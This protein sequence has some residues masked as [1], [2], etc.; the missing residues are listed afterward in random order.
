M[1]GVATSPDE[2]WKEPEI[3][4]HELTTE[5]LEEW[6]L[7][8]CT[9]PCQPGDSRVAR[10]QLPYEK[11]GHELAF[12]IEVFPAYVATLEDDERWKIPR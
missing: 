2:G 6:G 5:D 9:V 12:K 7:M 8:W 4:P 11:L 1:A 3:S 10:P